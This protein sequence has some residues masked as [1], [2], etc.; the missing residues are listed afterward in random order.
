MAVR[1]LLN[2][3]GIVIRRMFQPDQ[4]SAYTYY[5]DA[6][7]LGGRTNAPSILIEQGKLGDHLT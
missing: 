1:L 2:R 3:R 5:R 6:V 7:A 4:I